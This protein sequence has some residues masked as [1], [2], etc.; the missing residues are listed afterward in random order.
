MKKKFRVIVREIVGTETIVFSKVYDFPCLESA[1]KFFYTEIGS[2]LYSI[3]DIYNIFKCENDNKMQ[4]DIFCRGFHR[5]FIL[6]K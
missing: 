3:D 2:F 1:R 4:L 6:L 5:H